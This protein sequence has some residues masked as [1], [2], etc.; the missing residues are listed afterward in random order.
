ML[1]H[2]GAFIYSSC[3]SF[4][5]FVII[6]FSFILLYLLLACFIDTVCFYQKNSEYARDLISDLI[7]VDS[8]TEKTFLTIYFLIRLHSMQGWIATNR[9]GVTRKRRRKGWKRYKIQF[10]FTKYNLFHILPLEWLFFSKT[11]MNDINQKF[12]IIKLLS[13]NFISYIPVNFH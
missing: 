13:K 10:H 8:K 7:S 2:F 1:F 6:G 3:C 12:N 9:H 4:C 11:L 5:F